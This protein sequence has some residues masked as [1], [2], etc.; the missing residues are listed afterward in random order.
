MRDRVGKG[1]K[2]VSPLR[3]LAIAGLDLSFCASLWS[4][5]VFSGRKQQTARRV[6]RQGSAFVLQ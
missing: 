6:I 1:M 5:V 2:G 4:R 3:R